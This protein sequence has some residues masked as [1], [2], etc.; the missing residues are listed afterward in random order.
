MVG[1]EI[2]CTVIRIESKVVQVTH[3]MI[4]VI[5]FKNLLKLF[6]QHK[7]VLKDPFACACL[8]VCLYFGGG[9]GR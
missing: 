6:N 8:L 9:L 5:E 2:F 4:V 3:G 7:G 1:C